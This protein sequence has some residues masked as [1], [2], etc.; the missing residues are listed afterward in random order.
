MNLNKTSLRIS[1]ETNT[2]LIIVSRLENTT[3]EKLA[4]RLLTERLKPMLDKISRQR[5]K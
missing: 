2:N 4:E 5:F 3:K 1:K